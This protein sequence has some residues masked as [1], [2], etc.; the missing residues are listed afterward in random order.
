MMTSE[1]PMRILVVE[2]DIDFRNLLAGFIKDAFPNADAEYYHPSD[3]GR[4]GPDFE[5]ARFDVLILDFQLGAGENGLD[6]LRKFKRLSSKFPATI[7]LTA[8]GNE[9]VAVRAL[10]Y[11]AHDYLRK[12]NLNSKKLTES[13]AD[14]L[15]VRYR[16]SSAE[17]SLTINASKF[18]KSYFYAQLELAFEE[19]EKGESRALLL[20][21][22]DGY[23]SLRKSFG[24]LAME[25]VTRHLANL[26]MET[27]RFQ[28][29]VPRATRFSDASIGLLVG[30]YDGKDEL[31]LFLKVL[32]AR[33]RRSPPL[34][35]DAAIPVTISIGAA[36]INFRAFG[37]H[38]LFEHA[39]NATLEA[40]QKDGNSFVVVIPDVPDDRG[41]V[42]EECTVAF[43]AAAAV[44]EDRIQAMFVPIMPVSNRSSNFPVKEFYEINPSFISRDGKSIPI[45]TV[46]FE[47]LHDSLARTIDRWSLNECIGR[48]LPEDSRDEYKPTFLVNL[49]EASCADSTMTAWFDQVLKKDNEQ[50]R[51]N[52]ICLAVSQNDMMHHSKA[53]LSICQNLHERWGIRFVLKDVND[54][55]LCKICLTQFPF[56]MVVLE[57]D[58]VET[59]FKSDRDSTQCRKIIDIAMNRGVL[60]MARRI[61]DIKSLYSVISAGID[62]VHGPFIAPEQEEIEALIGIEAVQGGE[63][64]E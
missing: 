28:T 29:Y 25:D 4:P 50:R 45:N 11:G 49:S 17:R 48:L 35:H 5:W 15:N 60:T 37:V 55:D 47:Q 52:E 31:E 40:E 39:Y 46:P 42:A 26:G 18:S 19:G 12:Q 14:A 34:V 10:R 41:R 59:L 64:E 22:T 33:V 23:N 61:E 6:W 13:I 38:D 9:D 1:K 56:G 44:E 51:F 58:L 30:G 36:V 3:A 62:F 2:D 21:K 20:I 32:C 7:L 63:S 27:F 57:S 53:A 16:E 43:D 8:E 54:S 24:V